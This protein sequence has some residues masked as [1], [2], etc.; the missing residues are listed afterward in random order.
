MATIPK[1]VR[2]AS[3]PTRTHHKSSKRP[4]AAKKGKSMTSTHKKAAN[5]GGKR[6]KAKN[7]QHMYKK[8]KRRNPS[9]LGSIIGSPKEAIT[10]GLAGL[11][12]AVATRQIPQMLLQGSNTG[13]EGYAANLFTALASTWAASSFMGPAAG[14]G[15]L[16]GGLVILI[17]RVLSEQVSPLGPYLQ[18]SGIGDATAY[19]KLGTIRQGYYT[20]PNL[21]LPDGSMYV[22][23]PITDAA[24]QAVAAKYPQLAQPMA[25]AMA[26]GG[27]MGAVNPSSLRRHTANGMLLSSRFQGRF[28]S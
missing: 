4:N 1:K 28:N 25:A 15:A 5:G 23:D 12:S 11:A 21:Q 10:A 9:G 19:S 24:V 17:D 13:V 2:V 26:Q 14:R 6:K 3:N 27:K 7:P 8:A 16:I 22:P 20:H 18:L